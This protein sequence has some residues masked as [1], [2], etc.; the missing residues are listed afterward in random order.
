MRQP[1]YRPMAAQPEAGDVEHGH[2]GQ[3]DRPARLEVP[4]GRSCPNLENNVSRLAVVSMTPLG[5]PVVPDV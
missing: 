3:V 4:V 1:K 2:D 5:R